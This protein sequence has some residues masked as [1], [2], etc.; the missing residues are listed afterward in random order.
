MDLT[1]HDID[2]SG[3]DYDGQGLTVS[4]QVSA[5][6][7]NLGSGDNTQAFDVLFFEDR[8]LTGVYEETPDRLLGVT[9]VADGLPSGQSM[10][11]TSDLSGDVQFVENVVWG[12]VDGTGLVAETNEEN[13]FARPQCTVY[14]QAGQFD[15]VIEWSRR[16]FDTRPDST[17][18][19]TTPVVVDLDENGIPDVIYSTHLTDYIN[20]GT[21]RAIRG[22]NGAELWSIVDPEYDVSGAAQLAVGDID[23]DGR[24]EVIA[25]HE[26]GAL[27]AFEHDGTFKWKSVKVGTWGS[28]YNWGGPAIANIDGSG[29][30]RNHHGSYSPQ[31]RW[32]CPVARR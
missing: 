16:D 12:F 15:P 10:T 6:I 1:I 27:L 17:R 5:R 30:R 2:T 3:L 25:V 28:Y 23:L 21:L 24:P 22:D 18:I 26:S 29:A 32:H 13:N 19:L 8:N 7:A 11:V 14:P 20:D 31:Q 4:G 9:T